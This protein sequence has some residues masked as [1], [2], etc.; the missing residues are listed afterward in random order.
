MQLVRRLR[1]VRT[2]HFFAYSWGRLSEKW[3]QK[4]VL[5]C[6]L[7]PLK[8]VN[9]IFI[10]LPPFLGRGIEIIFHSILVIHSLFNNILLSKH[11]AL[12]PRKLLCD[13][14][15]I[16]SF[17]N[18]TENL[19]QLLIKAKQKSRKMSRSQKTQVVKLA[20]WP[21]VTG[22][23]FLLLFWFSVCLYTATC[24]SISLL[25]LHC[26]GRRRASRSAY[27][28]SGPPRTRALILVSSCK[29]FIHTDHESP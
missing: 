8:L 17:P 5:F 3:S 6:P 7:G 20:R 12:V 16:C 1:L 2:N 25:G 9:L 27:I 24:R 29:W 23:R 19:K 10:I 13:L 28:L 22:G 11:K 4:P 26:K 15:P 21:H 14:F 18:P